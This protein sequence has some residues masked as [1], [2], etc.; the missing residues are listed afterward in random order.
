MLDPHRQNNQQSEKFP[1][2][3]D[4]HKP[5]EIGPPSGLQSELA[6]KE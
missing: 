4:F 2:G 3:G 1:P 6:K 5:R